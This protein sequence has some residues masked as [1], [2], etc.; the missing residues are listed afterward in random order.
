MN[1]KHSD[2]NSAYL[3]KN[4][5]AMFNNIS[6]N[7]N[8]KSFKFLSENCYLRFNKR[9]NLQ[10]NISKY[11]TSTLTSSTFIKFVQKCSWL[12][13]LPI[14]YETIVRLSIIA[15]IKLLIYTFSFNNGILKYNTVNYSEMISWR[16]I[17]PTPKKETAL[18]RNF[19]ITI[20]Q[21]K[22]IGQWKYNYIFRLDR[23]AREYQKRKQKRSG[24]I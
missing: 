20:I 22:V 12:V 17:T 1:N 19:L 10:R 9:I 11:F 24:E 16:K 13:S 2:H 21:N 15:N 3:V 4:T 18:T 6:I 23:I 7:N 8:T 14:W 5:F